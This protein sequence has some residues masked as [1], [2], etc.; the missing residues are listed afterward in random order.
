MI[1]RGW[2]VAEL[3]K[4][5]ADREVNT[6]GNRANKTVPSDGANNCLK[7]SMSRGFWRHLS[8]CLLVCLNDG[9]CKVLAKGTRFGKQQDISSQSS[10][11]PIVLNPLLSPSAIA[12]VSFMVIDIVAVTS[13]S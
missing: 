3:G 5:A 13:Y 10:T 11:A 9:L 2:G 1:T 6:K 8:C 4:A 7:I 12:T